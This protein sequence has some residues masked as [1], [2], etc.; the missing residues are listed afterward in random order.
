MIAECLFKMKMFSERIKRNT[1]EIPTH[2]QDDKH[3]DPAGFAK[4]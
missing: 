3:N 2:D 4:R 1:N